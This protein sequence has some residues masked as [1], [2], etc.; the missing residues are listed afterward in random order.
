MPAVLEQGGSLTGIAAAREGVFALKAYA[1]IVVGLTIA[2]L[3]IGYLTSAPHEESKYRVWV[4]AQALGA[5]GG[6]TG[7]GIS[8]PDG[9]QAADFLGEGILNRVEAATG[10]SYD[11]LIDHLKLTQPPNGGP[12][13]PIELI[14]GA[15]SE[16][17]ARD[18]LGD[19]MAAVHQARMHYVKGLLARGEAGLQKSL[20]AAIRRNEPVTQRAIVDLLARMQALRPTLAVDYAIE[21]K[22]K[23]YDEATV[24]RPRKAVIG[25]IAG[26]IAGLALALLIALLG[27]RLRTPE[28]VEAALG[29]ELLADLRS[30]QGIPSAEHA[31]ERLRSLGS[32]SLPSILLLVPCGDVPTDAAASLSKAL[33][34]EVK[35][36]EPPGHQGFLQA[37]ERADAC[38]IVTKPGA[39]HRAEATALRAELD[40]VGITPAGLLAV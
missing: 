25:G 26:L 10:H 22:P 18:L 14:A 33:G 20:N 39:V 19:W 5:N 37:L 21:R 30:P 9:P 24:S 8:T 4:T 7:L 1:W 27:G 29:L 34:L 36:T 28:G 38:A 6:V 40:G 11:Y 2:G 31:R 3:V 16:A 15:D 13:P 12:N 17:A 23:A 32:G 35:L